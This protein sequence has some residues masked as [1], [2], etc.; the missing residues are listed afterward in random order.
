MNLTRRDLGK[1][2]LAALPATRLLAKTNSNF[3]GVQIGIN[4]PY[5]FHGAYNSGAECLDAMIRLNLSSVE[6]R[7]QP[8]E[9]F[10]GARPDLVAY[11][12][13]RPGG[14]ARGGSEAPASPP[15]NQPGAPAEPPKKSGGTRQPPT[16]EQIAARKANAE[17]LRA[18]RLA[19]SMDKVKEFRKKYEDAGVKIDIVKVDAIDTFTDEEIDYMFGLAATGGARAISC[20]IPL[21]HTKRLGMFGEKHKMMI[22]YHGHTDVTSP[23]AFGRPES[24]ET[25]MSYSKY[26]GINLDIGHFI[27]GNSTSPIPF[28]QKYHDRVTHIHIKD[29]KLHNGPNVPWGMGDTPITETLKLMQKEKYPFVGVIE[30]EYTVPQG[31]DAMTEI[32]KCVAYCKN[33]LA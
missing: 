15:A 18:W 28:L 1:L 10:M 11:P 4:A 23:E 17:E 3:G 29:R 30:F 5:S 2:A 16:P 9:Q 24:W 8:I 33:A 19:A 26:N 21:S 7:A 14:A 6:L 20:E 25:A 27:A 31:S 32:A 12:A 22:G 13:V